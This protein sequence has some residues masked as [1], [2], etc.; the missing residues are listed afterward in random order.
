MTRNSLL[1]TVAAFTVVMGA[2]T[3][4]SQTPMPDPL[5]DRSVK[6][7]EK[8]EKVVREL[9]SIVFQGRDSGKPVTVMPAETDS[10]IAALTDRVADLEETLTRLNGANET[11]TFQLE[12]AQ[13]ALATSDAANRALGDRLA[14]LEGRTTQSEAA[15]ATAAAA[16]PTEEEEAAADVGDPAADFAKARQFML[17]GDYDSAETAFSAFVKRYGDTEKGPEA[18][19]WLGKTLSVRGA[20]AEAAGA[21]IGAIRGWP[22]TSWAPD[23]TLELS[24]SLV[25]LKK[26][27]DACQT[28]DELARRYPKAPTAV[29]TRAQAVRTQARCAA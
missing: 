19:Y 9:R 20:N 6:R 18:R 28:L 23:A 27:A 16:G 26:P 11:L 21:F 4:W 17:D 7:L 10:Q 24:R 12:Q 2:A 14:A 25:A 8:M 22:R 29:L 13:K 1:A 5:D 3:A 15:A